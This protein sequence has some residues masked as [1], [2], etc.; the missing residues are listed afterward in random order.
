M[1]LISIIK[2]I[3]STVII[4]A[5]SNTIWTIISFIFPITLLIPIVKNVLESV[6][7]KTYAISLFDLLFVILFVVLEI[8]LCWVMYY[9]KSKSNNH[10]NESSDKSMIDDINKET[11]D[12]EI[13]YESLDY[14]FET[15]HKHLTVYKNG[16]GILINSFTVV[17]NNINSITE[18]RREINIC[19][20][21]EIAAFPKLR[22]MKRTKLHDRFE[23]FGFWYK[24][25]NNK[26]LIKSVR[27]YYWSDDL[28]SIDTISQ[29]DP[30]ILKWIMEM[31]PSSIEIGKPYNI[32][33]VM[34]IPN[35]FP[36][37]N[38]EFKDNIA[39]IKGTHGK[40]Q[41]KFAVK[42][43]MKHF[44]YTVSFENG[45]LLH[46]KPS[47]NIS[48]DGNKI[49]LHY[50]NDN[51]IIYDRYIFNTN[52]PKCNSVINIEWS[53]KESYVQRKNGGTNM[54]K[55]GNEIERGD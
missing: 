34:S 8:S 9:T 41:S 3:V 13:D 16:N 50:D 6:I 26:D 46:T 18:F 45:L 53:F 17:I 14:Y 48:L 24:C 4:W 42:H 44:T 2:K 15:Y 40:F 47:G 55:M 31:N 7:T 22:D 10:T 54:M 36:I 43:I 25:L 23:K 33:Y 39:N 32:V 1:K 38:G 29:T 27:E 37:E 35:M 52:N 51:N 49:N 20:A 11:K 5:I 21:K 19:D 30:K 12:D 28:K